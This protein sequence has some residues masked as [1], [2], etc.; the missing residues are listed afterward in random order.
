VKPNDQG[1]NG[2]DQSQTDLSLWDTVKAV[3]WSFLGIR[4]RADF[5][6]DV[7][8]LRP[9]HLMIVGIVLTFMFVMGLM[10]LVNWVVRV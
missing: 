3:L 8:R 1:Q 9:L 5:Q 6:K 7:E 2:K 10:L 4:R